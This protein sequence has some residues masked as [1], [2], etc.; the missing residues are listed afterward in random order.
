IGYQT[1]I[2]VGKVLT[3]AGVSVGASVLAGMHWAV[4]NRCE[5]ISM[6]LAG[7]G[8]V[9]PSYTAAG[10][11]ALNAGCLMIAA[12]G[13]EHAATGYP[14]NSPTIMSVPA[15]TPN[16]TPA[17]FSNFGKIDIAAPGVNV[18]SSTR[19]P[20][21]HAT[22]DGTSMATPHVSGC[23]ALWAQTDPSLRGPLL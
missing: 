3:N 23:A 5:V 22:M 1:N 9:Q 20:L 12:A 19:R 10:Q 16:L 7:K 13:N 17:P 6:S 15:L 4:A 21:L 8:P 2:F 11:A 18:F 14:A